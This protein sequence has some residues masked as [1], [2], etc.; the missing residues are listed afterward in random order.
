[1]TRADDLL[2]EYG[3]TRQSVARYVDLVVRRRPLQHAPD[4]VGL[5]ES[6]AHRVKDAFREMPEEDRLYLV[7]CAAA[8]RRAELEKADP[9]PEQLEGEQ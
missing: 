4:E 7:E 3:L 2:E 9:D 8:S 1:M 6:V 5:S